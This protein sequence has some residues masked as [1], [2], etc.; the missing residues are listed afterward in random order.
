MQGK[1]CD[2]G[3]YKLMVW[4]TTLS[5]S[6]TPKKSGCANQ[7]LNSRLNPVVYNMDTT[8]IERSTTRTWLEYE[9]Y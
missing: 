9:G 6:N 4:L 2:A 5:P 3:E 7:S 8:K 1:S